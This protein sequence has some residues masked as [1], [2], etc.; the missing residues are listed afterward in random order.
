[1]QIQSPRRPR[2]KS[3]GGQAKGIWRGATCL[4]VLFAGIPLLAGE[5]RARPPSFDN[6][7][8]DSVFYS[9]LSSAVQ[10]TRP[11]APE[12]RGAAIAKAT[13][14]A[15]SADKPAGQDDESGQGWEKLISAVSLE[16]EIKSTKLRF[17]AVITSPGPF[18]SGGYQDAR[19]DLS[20]LATLFAV[21]AEYDGEVR[22]KDESAAARDLMARTAFNCKAG[23]VQVYNEAKLR[24]TDLQDLVGG[25]GLNSRE[26]EPENDWSM[27]VDRTPLMEF[28]D[29]ALYDELQPNS[30]DAK[31][32]TENK[33]K[34]RKNAELIA[35]VGNVM[36]REGLADAEDEEYQ[37][38]AQVMVKSALS[39]RTGLEKNDAAAVRAA[40]GAVSQSCTACHDQYR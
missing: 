33:D 31:S 19:N 35:M 20:M 16:D 29:R 21:I 22:W 30:N 34:L 24:K 11:S 17:D 5:K 15:N 37:K 23:S 36:T 13:A 32:V 40:V 4:L 10:P 39:I 2:C 7:R 14:A 9:D 3:A 25:S 18:K 27:I 8:L 1:M 26:A 28:L 6:A 12:L 38:L